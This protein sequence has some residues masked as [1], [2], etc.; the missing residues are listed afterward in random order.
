MQLGCLHVCSWKSVEQSNE[1]WRIQH[2]PFSDAFTWQSL[3]VVLRG[4]ITAVLSKSSSS[5]ES[6]PPFS[7]WWHSTI[8]PTLRPHA[9]AFDQGVPLYVLLV[10]AVA[11]TVGTMCKSLHANGTSFLKRTY[12]LGQQLSYFMGR[13]TFFIL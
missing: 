9:A 5:G 2:Q 11:A 10:T 8:P 3:F 1:R 12:I 13:A 6:T 4:L 7:P